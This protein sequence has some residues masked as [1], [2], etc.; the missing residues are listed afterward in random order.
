MIDHNLY[1]RQIRIFGLDTQKKITDSVV[2]IIYKESLLLVN[3][4]VKNLIL[5]GVRSVSVKTPEIHYSN[6]PS[7][8]GV[9]G[10]EFLQNFG[11][12]SVDFGLFNVSF[13][14]LYHCVFFVNI[15]ICFSFNALFYFNIFSD[16]HSINIEICNSI[17]ALSTINQSYSMTCN[18]KERVCSSVLVASLSCEF[19]VDALSKNNF[20][21]I[22]KC[23][24]DTKRLEVSLE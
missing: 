11:N 19:F 14:K 7:C 3:E 12:S 16:Q 6:Q 10:H 24:V 17:T 9:N 23:I 22:K 5:L 21:K 20:E 18:D 1:D 4:L 15:P 2:L 13:E 8:F